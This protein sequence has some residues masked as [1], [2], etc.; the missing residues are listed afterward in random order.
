[1]R[2]DLG[3]FDT[4]NNSGLV[5]RLSILRNQSNG[6]NGGGDFRFKTVSKR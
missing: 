5:T 1:M 6:L 3:A 4:E 2:P